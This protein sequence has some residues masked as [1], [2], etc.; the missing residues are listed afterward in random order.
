MDFKKQSQPSS[1]H[2]SQEN[3]LTISEYE[4]ISARLE[5]SHQLLDL[6]NACLSTPENYENMKQQVEQKCEK[7]TARVR[8]LRKQKENESSTNQQI[9]INIYK[10][11]ITDIEAR[12]G[13]LMLKHNKNR[14]FKLLEGQ[15]YLID[16]VKLIIN[17]KGEVVLSSTSTTV[18]RLVK[19]DL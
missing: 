5:D 2:S 7:I 6:V 11:E 12:R 4:E 16:K 17:K 15:N 19:I 3:L 8:V 1:Q 14:K 18:I 13:Y 10:I 9:V